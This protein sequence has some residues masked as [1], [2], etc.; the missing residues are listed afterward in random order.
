M[1]YLISHKVSFLLHTIYSY[2]RNCLRRITSHS[3]EAEF[4]SQSIMKAIEKFV[5]AVQEMDETI[6]VP[7]RLMDL[8]VGDAT[9][10]VGVKSSKRVG[11]R[12]RDGLHS[13]DLHSL[14]TLVNL[15]KTEL[16]WGAN[17]QPPEEEQHTHV[18]STAIKT[19][20]RRPSTASMASMNSAGSTIS[21]T[22]SEVGI[23][24]DSGIEGETESTTK[25]S[26]TQKVEE[27]FRRHL[28]GLHRS[29]EQMTDAAGYLT[30]RYQ[31]EIG[32]AV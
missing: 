30:K 32:G 6:L 12:E 9:D 25:P 21:D 7:C 19:H 14:Y 3:S 11:E 29:L 28:Y 16:L 13:T 5:Q 1:F 10:T 2:F 27:S 24:N 20:I 8:Q 15:V 31:N 17:E 22:D 23:E 26:Y 4:S 18:T